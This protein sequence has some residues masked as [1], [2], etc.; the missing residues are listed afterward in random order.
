MV[1]LLVALT[2]LGFAVRIGFSAISLGSNDWATWRWFAA[3][4]ICTGPSAYAL[5]PT[6]NHPPIPVLWSC[7]SLLL[8]AVTG[9]NFP[10][11]FRLPSIAADLGSCVLLRRIWAK[12][13]HGFDDAALGE[14]RATSETGGDQPVGRGEW[15]GWA[16]S[17][18]MAWNLDAVLVGAYHCNT[19]NVCAFLTLLSAYQLA[20]RRNALR[21]G[22]A[23]AAAIN[24]K[25]VPVLMV[26][27]LLVAAASAC[28]GWRRGGGR[29]LLG[30]AAGLPPFLLM[31]ALVPVAFARNALAY[32][33]MPG[34]W[35][36]MLLAMDAHA[37]PLIAAKAAVV[38]AWYS[39][40]GKHVVL[41]AAGLLSLAALVRPRR[42][43]AYQLAAM[44]SALFLLLTPGFG[45]QYTV[46]A[47]PLML[48]VDLRRGSAYGLVAGLYL[49]ATYAGKWDGRLPLES[50]FM[51]GAPNPLPPP[52]GFVAW[53][54]LAGFV[55]RTLWC[56]GLVDG[57]D[58]SATAT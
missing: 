14:D 9:I 56:R 36:F 54:L 53:A 47:V 28:G 50:M 42:W 52:I 30:L 32:S 44:T 46:Y 2:F 27:A 23:L 38:A 39:A 16:A 51:G 37:T 48:A 31:F 26:P 5:E 17:A 29:F 58:R 49:L 10:F 22:L 19:D 18:A 20:H 6:L 11:V 8:C 33:P 40:H 7:S 34:E 3:L 21:G 1:R 13:Y 43:D 57:D 24:I 4:A 25:L 35:G 41:A 15:V 45:L 12:R 55:W